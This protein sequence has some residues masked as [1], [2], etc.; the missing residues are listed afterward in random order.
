MFLKMVV[1][2]HFSW[3]N[4][5][6]LLIENIFFIYSSNNEHLG[7]FH[8]MCAMN[9]VSSAFQFNSRWSQISV[10]GLQFSLICL[11]ISYSLRR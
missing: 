10:F 6:P 8:V 7:C 1:F 2:P 3:L 11:M 5:I 9:Y 4:D